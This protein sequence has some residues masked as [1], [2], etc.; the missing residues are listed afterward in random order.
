M[1][2]FARSG[3]RFESFQ[4]RSVRVKAMEGSGES[5]TPVAP[6]QF[7]SPTGQFLSQIMVTHPHLLP[8]AIDQQLER[9]QTDSE[10]QKRGSAPSPQDLLYRFEFKLLFFFFQF[11][12][13]VVSLRELGLCFLKS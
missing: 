7:E 6:L 13:S 1:F 11:L 8:A 9:L 4:P 10:A 2:G 12:L 5:Q 3:V